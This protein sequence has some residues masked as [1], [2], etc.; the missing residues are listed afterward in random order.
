MQHHDIFKQQNRDK[1][2]ELCSP[3]CRAIRLPKKQTYVKNR[4]I[5]NQ[6]SY[7]LT[8]ICF[9]SALF[10][11]A[12]RSYWPELPFIYVVTKCLQHSGLR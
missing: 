1:S 10:A 9:T 3:R 12:Q 8:A 7:K 4:L 6:L 2:S 11:S 5:K